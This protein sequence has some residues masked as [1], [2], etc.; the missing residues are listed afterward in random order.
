MVRWGKRKSMAD[1]KFSLAYSRFLGYEKG[2]DGTLRIVEE[3][4]E[5]IRKIY[6]LYLSGQ[7]VRTNCR[8][9]DRAGRPY[10]FRPKSNGAFPLL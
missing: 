4:A 6:S 10:A 8:L 1:G 9:S 7:T 5:I 3:E 2:G